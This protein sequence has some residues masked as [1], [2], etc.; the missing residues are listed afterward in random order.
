MMFVRRSSTPVPARYRFLLLLAGLSLIAAAGARAP[1]QTTPAAPSKPAAHSPKQSAPA[2]PS[3]TTPEK[4]SKPTVMRDPATTVIRANNP[5]EDARRAKPDT[6]SH[7]LPIPPVRRK[8]GCYRTSGGQWVEI[9]CLQVTAQPTRRTPPSNPGGSGIASLPGS[10]PPPGPPSG[11]LLPPPIPTIQSTPHPGPVMYSDPAHPLGQQ[12]TLTTPFNWGSVTVGQP[13]PAAGSETNV[14]TAPFGG[15]RPD[16]FSIQV[17]TNVFT[18]TTCKAGYPFSDANVGDNAWVQFVYTQHGWTPTPLENDSTLCVWMVDT[19]ITTADEDS[20]VYCVSPS[21][22]DSVLPID[23]MDAPSGQAEVAGFIQCPD[24]STTTGCTIG[25]LAH[26]PWSPAQDWW[27]ASGPDLMGLAGNW[28]NVSGGIVGMSNGS[29]AV[30]TNT[31]VETTVQAYTCYAPVTPE[32]ATPGAPGEGPGACAPPASPPNESS[33][34]L[35]LTAAD[36][37]QISPTDETNNLTIQPATLS[38]GYYDC[39]L[40]YNSVEPH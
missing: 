16:S 40:T 38:C 17:N 28:T 35:K 23:G 18:C 31:S 9:P 21:A 8:P 10:A 1:K 26:L 4:P 11:P 34:W 7:K 32:G 37:W 25:I 3:K 5:T 36:R 20:T 12:T 2:K 29:Q 33:P 15:S 22:A 39:S 19:S 27:M 24:P 13:N 14:I 30:F 6:P